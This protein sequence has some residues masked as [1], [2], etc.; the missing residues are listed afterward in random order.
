MNCY[1][2]GCF[3]ADFRGLCSFYA[4]TEHDSTLFYCWVITYVVLDGWVRGMRFGKYAWR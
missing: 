4:E 1:V 3:T 2:C